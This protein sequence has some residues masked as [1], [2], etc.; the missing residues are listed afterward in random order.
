MVRDRVD[1]VRDGE[2]AGADRDLVAGEPVGIAAAV[3]A[4]VMRPDDLDACVLE[5]VDAADHLR[6]EHGVRL[7]QPPLGLA[8]RARLQQDLVRHA[9]LA[10]VVQKE[11]VLQRGIGGELRV[12]HGRKLD[13]VALNPLRVLARAR[14]LRAER[15]RERRDGFTVRALQQS[16]L[17]SLELDEVAEVACVE[18]ELLLAGSVGRA[19]HGRAHARSGQALDDAEQLERA[20]RLQ[21]QCVGAGGSRDLLD[22]LH[23]GQQHDPD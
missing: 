12:E 16:A 3:P 22:V 17:G 7:H 15:R 19:A 14:V 11:A 20:E 10:D 5:E 21:Q 9:D 1:G 6:A 8:Q 18:D 2:D 4:L 23:P 13:G